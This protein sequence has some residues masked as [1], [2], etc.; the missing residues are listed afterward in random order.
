MR[1]GSCSCYHSSL[2]TIRYIGI[3]FQ[4][5]FHNSRCGFSLITVYPM[6]QFIIMLSDYFS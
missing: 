4:I 6:K 5:T 2:S 1:L 3:D